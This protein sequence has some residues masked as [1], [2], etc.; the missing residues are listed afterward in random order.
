[1]PSKAGYRT[2]LSLQLL[3]TTFSSYHQHGKEKSSEKS[4]RFDRYCSYLEYVE[5]LS[6]TSE[7][8]AERGRDEWD[9]EWRCKCT[10]LAVR[11]VGKDSLVGGY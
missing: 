2:L 8:D 5:G 10:T 3:Q 6:E 4:H 11:A 7:E 9:R 1:M